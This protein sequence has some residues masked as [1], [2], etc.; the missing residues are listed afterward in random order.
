MA[1]TRPKKSPVSTSSIEENNNK[2]KKNK[3]LL[4]N[5][6]IIRKPLMSYERVSGFYLTKIK[7]FFQKSIFS[8]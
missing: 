5:N 3:F 2:S 8:I 7:F 1:N 6:D 4:N